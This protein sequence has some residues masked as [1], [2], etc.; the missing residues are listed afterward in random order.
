MTGRVEEVIGERGEEVTLIFLFF[1]KSHW[2]KKK[3]I[4]SPLM[5]YHLMCI[6]P[7]F[8]TTVHAKKTW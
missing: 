1:E 4:P 5:D 3:H 8:Q 6:A 7:L 2:K